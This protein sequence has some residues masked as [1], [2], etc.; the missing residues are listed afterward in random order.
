LQNLRI[1][2]I[3]WREFVRLPDLASPKIAAK[4]HG[5]PRPFSSR[6]MLDGHQE[7]AIRYLRELTE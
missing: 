7:G 4:F 5:C 6:L 2:Q 1:N 3:A